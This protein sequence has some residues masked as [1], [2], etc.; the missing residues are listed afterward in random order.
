ME[1]SRAVGLHGHC[2]KFPGTGLWKY[3]IR[4]RSDNGAL[5]PLTLRPAGLSRSPNAKDWSIYEDGVEIG[6]VCEDGHNPFGANRWF[7]SLTAMGPARHLLACQ[8]HAA[9]LGDRMHFHRWK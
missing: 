4:R 2:R 3:A 5:M 1:A 8:G 9:T 7:W 6:R